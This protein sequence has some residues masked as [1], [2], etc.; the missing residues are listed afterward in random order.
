[1]KSKICNFLLTAQDFHAIL[2]ERVKRIQQSRVSALTL[3]QSGC[4]AFIK[5]DKNR[6]FVLFLCE[7]IY[8]PLIF[9]F[10]LMEVFHY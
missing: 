8:D 9:M 6:V 10:I 1:M 5:G 4:Q 2:S 3:R 7:W